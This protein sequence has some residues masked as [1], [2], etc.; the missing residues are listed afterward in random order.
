MGKVQSIQVLRALAVMAVVQAHVFTTGRGTSG[1]DLFFVISGF[2]IARVSSDRPPVTFVKARLWRILP[3]YWLAALPYV[4]WP[5]LYGTPDWAKIAATV[6][7][8]PVWGG[9]YQQ[10]LLPVAWSLY[11]EMLFYAAVALWLAGKRLAA[12]AAALVVVAAL[13]VPGP[14][15]AFLLSP[16]IIEFLAGFA[17]AR[18]RSFRLALLALIIGLIWLFTPERSFEGVTMLDGSTAW[19]RLAMYGVPASLI[20]YGALGL[21]SWFAEPW[22]KPIVLVGDASYSIYL[23]HLMAVRALAEW[24]AP[25]RLLAALALGLACYFTIERTL[26]RPPSPRKRLVASPA[27]DLRPSAPGKANGALTSSL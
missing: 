3:V 11:F 12:G 20:V 17:L 2:I 1:V 19:L 24:S 23:T 25:V 16:I 22:A 14:V 4:A 26:G 9:T 8:W 27:S 15:T 6:T 18:V 10:P 7:L 5:I 21:E 13:V